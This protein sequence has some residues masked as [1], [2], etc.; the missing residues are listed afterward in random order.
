[1]K[2]L[3][4]QYVDGTNE[5]YNVEDN[6]AGEAVAALTAQNPSHALVIGEAV[7]Y[8]NMRQVC[9]VAVGRS[10]DEVTSDEPEAD[11]RTVAELKEDLDAAGIEYPATAKKADLLELASTNGI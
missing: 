3:T 4:I 9:S 10:E 5:S 1:M 6:T 7:V 8:V 11:P 2:T